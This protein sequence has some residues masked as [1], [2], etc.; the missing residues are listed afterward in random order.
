MDYSNIYFSENPEEDIWLNL[1]RYSFLNNIHKYYSDSDINPSDDLVEVIS[2]SI[3]QA[4]EYFQASKVATIQTAPLLLYYGATNLLFGASC[5]L[6]GEILDVKGHGMKLVDQENLNANILDN[7]IKLVDKQTGGFSVYLNSIAENEIPINSEW[8]I[9][10]LLGSIP[11]IYKEFI[12][13]FDKSFLSIIP[14]E[15]VIS[16]DEDT[17]RTN[18]KILEK[19][20]V[21]NKIENVIDLKTNYLP[22]TINGK[23]QIVFRSKMNKENLVKQSYYNESY[24]SVGHKKNKHLYD[25]DSIFYEYMSLF[26]LA[27]IC[28]YHP[29]M[30]TPFVRTDNSGEVNFIEKF[31]ISVRRYFPNIVLDKLQNTRHFYSNQL[32]IPHDI[33]SNISEKEIDTKIRNMIARLEN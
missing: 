33:R 5:L 24:F 29:Q 12:E 9:I 17:Y 8:S 10:E 14:L 19:S 4:Y 6:S 11:E 25:F 3:L 32:A 2:G 1:K 15:R 16:D 18:D 21:I 27:T 13:T 31:L 26:G 20:E 23:G 22:H 28:R 7:K 30:W